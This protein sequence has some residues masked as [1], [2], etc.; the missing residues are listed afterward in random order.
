MKILIGIPAFNE[1][2]MIGNVI[3]SIPDNFKGIDKADI[4]VVSDGSTDE[5]VKISQSNGAVVLNHLINIGLGGAL[6]TIFAYAKLNQ[7]DFLVTLDA[8]GQHEGSSIS[9]LI[10]PILKRNVNI[11]IGTRWLKGKNMPLIRLLTNKFANII[12]YLLFGV[13]SSDSQSGFRAFDKLAINKINLITDGMEVSSEFFKEIKSHKLKFTEIPIKAIYTDYS[14]NKGQ[15]MSNSPE[16]LLRL[17][18]RFFQ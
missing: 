8:D 13:Y 12:T 6:K 10:E 3:K 2:L 1:A 17:F 4:L 5:T 11:V 18:I 9:Q 15:K 14:K 7:Y 16:I